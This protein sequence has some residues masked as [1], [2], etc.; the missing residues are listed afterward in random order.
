MTSSGGVIE[1][2]SMVGVAKIIIMILVKML[3][4]M[5]L[6][7]KWSDAVELYYCIYYIFSFKQLT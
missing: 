4:I 7:F 5:K 6:L 3:S 2:F 1:Q